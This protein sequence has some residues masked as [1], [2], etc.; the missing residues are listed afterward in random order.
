MALTMIEEISAE[1]MQLALKDPDVCLD[2]I[3][4][5]DVP[6]SFVP[7]VVDDYPNPVDVFDLNVGADE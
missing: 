4:T 2:D 1:L 7:D 3:D 5:S 6:V